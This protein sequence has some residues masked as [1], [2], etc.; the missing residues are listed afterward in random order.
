MPEGLGPD[1]VGEVFT[2]RARTVTEADLVQFSGLSWDV[3]VAHTDSVGASELPFGERVAHG[4][5]IMSMAL[6]LA[7]VDGPRYPWRAG[8]SLSWQ[9]L[10]PVR[11]G[12]TIRTTWSITDIAPTRSDET[13]RVTSHCQ[14]YNQRDEVVQEGDVLRLAT[15]LAA[16]EVLGQ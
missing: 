6:G 2:T 14:V 1:A 7:V 13:I 9:F 5:L 8:L 16:P 12:D 3:N 15:G 10:R 4:P 11:I